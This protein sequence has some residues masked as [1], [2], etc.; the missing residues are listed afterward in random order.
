MCCDC[1]FY[2]GT[3]IFIMPRFFYCVSLFYLCYV[4]LFYHIA[5]KRGER[6][7]LHCLKYPQ[8]AVAPG[9]GYKILVYAHKTFWNATAGRTAG[10]KDEQVI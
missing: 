10:M 4:R 6:M 2:C 5:H 7:P 9:V 3:T 1:H 8:G